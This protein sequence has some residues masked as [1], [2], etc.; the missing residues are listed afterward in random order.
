MLSSPVQFLR[1][2]WIIIHFEFSRVFLSAR[3]WMYLFTFGLLWYFVLNYWVLSIASLIPQD[4]G[5]PVPELNSYWRVALYLFPGLCLVITAN[6]TCSDRSRGT[7]RFLVLRASRDSIFFGRFISQL[8]IQMVLVLTTAASVLIMAVM[9]DASVMGAGLESAVIIVT[10]LFVVLIPITAMMSL[11]SLTV[12]S[13]RQVMVLAA[14][15]WVLASAVIQ[16]ISHY[17][18]FFEV[19]ELIIPGRQLSALSNLPQA[20]TLSLAY[21]PLLQGLVLLVVGR[22]LMQRTSL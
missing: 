13:T 18:P 9:H 6:Q 1:S 11:L 15:I 21:I 8:L 3:G 12:N 16:G 4:I 2:M 19:F 5:W 22:F 14:L 17:F 10:N 20:E 7:L